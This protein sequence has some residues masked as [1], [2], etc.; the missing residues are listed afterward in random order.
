MSHVWTIYVSY[1]NHVCIIHLSSTHHVGVRL[2]ASLHNARLVRLIYLLVLSSLCI[3][4]CRLN[5][6]VSC[7]HNYV[8]TKCFLRQ[9]TLVHIIHASRKQNLF[10]CMLGCLDV[11]MFCS[12]LSSH[13]CTFLSLCLFVRAFWRLH[14]CLIACCAYNLGVSLF[15]CLLD[16]LIMFD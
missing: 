10:T 9:A 2:G 6:G 13:M 1:T 12:F 4:L 7:T 14:F 5:Y 16:C 8:T 11:C 15:L 3:L